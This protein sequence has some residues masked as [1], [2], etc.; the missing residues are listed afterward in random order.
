[1]KRIVLFIVFLQTTFFI[2]GQNPDLF[3]QKGE[4]AEKRNNYIEAEEN[5]KS[6]I[7]GY[8]NKHDTL[9]FINCYN[10]IARIRQRDRDYYNVSKYIDS[11]INFS[12]SVRYTEG[13][14][15]AY[16]VLAVIYHYAD[17]PS[18]AVYYAKMGLD[19]CEQIDNDTLKLMAM[20]TY[21]ETL[22]KKGDFVYYSL[23]DVLS[24]TISDYKDALAYFD[25]CLVISK[26]VDDSLLY[27]GNCFQG[28]GT[29]LRR[30]KEI[31]K[32]SIAYIYNKALNYYRQIP[33]YYQLA[34]HFYRFGEFYH[35]IGDF[36]TSEINY[37]SAIYYA[38]KCIPISH[39]IISKTKQ[40]QKILEKSVE[41]KENKN[42]II[43]FLAVTGTLLLLFLVFLRKHKVRIIQNKTLIKTSEE[44]E[45]SNNALEEAYEKVST[46]N[47]IGKELTSN[48]DFD[49]IIEVVY[50]KIYDLMDE[51]EENSFFTIGI[52]KEEKEELYFPRV[53][54]ATTSKDDDHI[55]LSSTKSFAVKCFNNDEKDFIHIKDAELEYKEYDI[56]EMESFNKD[57]KYD[58][59]IYVQLKS[60]KTEKKL[61]VISFQSRNKNAFNDVHINLL[62]IFSTYTAIAI[63]NSNALKKSQDSL[64]FLETLIVTIPAAFFY[65][66]IKSQK[67][68][69]CNYEYAK[70]YGKRSYKDII[71]KTIPEVHLE[72]ADKIK[73]LDNKNFKGWQTRL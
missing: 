31:G 30:F 52:Y 29:V 41:I 42:L 44:L 62:R 66:D 48:K 46:I 23:T 65:F 69:R 51:K 10:K 5:Y 35:E 18:K 71:G 73:K 12:D 56:T 64:N 37:D 22:S 67:Y 33:D 25:S 28:K 38:D 2:Y 27:L 13:F 47:E 14:V 58:S 60:A 26:T 43:F 11:A 15:N 24:D 7:K 34:E 50:K 63:E 19:S 53:Q 16:H 61:G 72:N 59:I 8:K 20:Y 54:T 4:I 3:F 68:Q 70:L 9:G 32:D 45:T 17:D 39:T 40:K 1:M 55:S 49:E 57:I 6:A 21:A 36:K